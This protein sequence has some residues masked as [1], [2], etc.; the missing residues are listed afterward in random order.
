MT[1]SI[2]IP[3]F[4][5]DRYIERCIDSILKQSFTDWTLYLVDDGST[6]RSGNICNR[7]SEVDSRIKTIHTPNNGQASA[8]N[9]A[10]NLVKSEYLCFID[11]DDLLLDEDSLYRSVEFLRSN[12]SIDFI[13]FPS[14]RFVTE[15]EI[16]Q[17]INRS[18]I[19][20]D[21]V[22]LSSKKEF[23]EHTDIVNSVRPT[24]NILKTSPWG[25]V[26]RASL[27]KDIR[28]PEGMVFEDTY[29]FCDLFE[30]TNKMAFVNTGLYGNF[31]RFGST[32]CGTPVA[33][34]MQDKIKAYCKIFSTLQT[35]STDKQLLVKYYIW[36]LNLISAFYSMFGNKFHIKKEL[37]YLISQSCC[38]RDNSIIS[39]TIALL[40]IMNY[41][42][43]RT[44]YYNLKKRLLSKR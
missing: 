42:H 21:V 33:W 25:K 18:H 32:T 36:I 22:I 24:I 2:I 39:K 38:L 35:Y 12:S 8:R 41:I 1:L 43:L 30:R 13:Q 17:H 15:K 44:Q 4:N 6:D 40:G 3:V 27:F 23:I 34:K 29:M 14:I 28:F 10:L 11:A 5:V 16:S 31:E 7:Y 26:F 20:D 9:K 37:D 19:N